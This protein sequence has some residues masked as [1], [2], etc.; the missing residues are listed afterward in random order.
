MPVPIEWLIVVWRAL[1]RSLFHW[2]GIFEGFL[3]SAVTSS[4]TWPPQLF[5][6]LTQD[7][8][9]VGIQL[10]VHPEHQME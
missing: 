9:P 4:L 5:F 2:E 10:G 3:G 1:P 8:C 6:F 7:P